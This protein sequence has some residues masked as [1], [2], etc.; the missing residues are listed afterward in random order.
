MER[1]ICKNNLALGLLCFQLPE[2]SDDDSN[3]TFFAVYFW[4]RFYSRPLVLASHGNSVFLE[5]AAAM[6][7]PGEEPVLRQTQRTKA[8]TIETYKEPGISVTFMG[9]C[10]NQFWCLPSFVT[11]NTFLFLYFKNF[12]FSI[13]GDLQCSVNF[14]CTAKWPS[15][16]YI[17][18]FFFSYYPHHVSSQVTRY[19]SLCY[20]AGS[21]CLSIPKAIVCIC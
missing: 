8:N 15:H 16:N 18:T 9:Y 13:V 4:Y 20:T 1:K 10:F 3:V 21:H 7:L 19:T 17:Y 12:T 5:T 14:C 11:C 6:L 2:Q